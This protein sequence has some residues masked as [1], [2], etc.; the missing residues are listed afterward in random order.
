MHTMPNR[1]EPVMAAF[2]NW[3][4][5]Q[6]GRRDDAVG[7]LAGDLEKDERLPLG[8]NAWRAYLQQFNACDGAF[9]ALDSA[10]QEFDELSSRGLP[11]PQTP[12]TN[13]KKPGRQSAKV[14]P[15]ATA[16]VLDLTEI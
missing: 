3:L 13:K 6:A 11:K 14:R 5:Q 4:L 2:N 12:Q 7:D 16:M 1:N 9:Q 8:H 10:W 15:K